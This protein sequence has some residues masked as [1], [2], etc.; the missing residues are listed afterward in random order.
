MKKLVS[1]ITVLMMFGL[2]ACSGSAAVTTSAQ[3]TTTAATT[4]TP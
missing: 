3:E 4:Q 1:S 2:T